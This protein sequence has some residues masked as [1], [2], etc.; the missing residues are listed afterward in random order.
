ME[1]AEQKLNA[2]FTA[3]EEHIVVHPHELLEMFKKYAPHALTQKE[4]RLLY[5]E[6]NEYLTDEESHKLFVAWEKMHYENDLM[7]KYT[8]S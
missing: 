8:P 5:K 4:A 3:P 1:K 7:D 6:L 2:F